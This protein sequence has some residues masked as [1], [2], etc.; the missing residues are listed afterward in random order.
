[1]WLLLFCQL[2]KNIPPVNKHITPSHITTGLTRQVKIKPLNLLGMA[3]SPQDSHPI[4]LI[5]R[6]RTRPHLRIKEPGGH[7]IH[8]RKLAP[9]PGQRLAKVRH[10]GFGPVVDGLVGGYVDDVG[11]HAGRDDEVSAVLA[12]KDLAC[13][14]GAVDDAV[15]VDGELFLVFGEG[16][17]EDWF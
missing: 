12:R 6:Q 10:K 15:D 4:S 13:V 5:N 8:A 17:L 7:N 3:L 1:M 14:F 2:R 11:A 9:L 16:L